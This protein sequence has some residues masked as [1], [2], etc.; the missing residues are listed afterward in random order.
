L[1]CIRRLRNAPQGG[2]NMTKKEIMKLQVREQE[3]WEIIGDDL[4]ELVN[5]LIDIN[6][7]LE[8]E[9]NQ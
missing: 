4:A 7:E 5:E 1:R 2:N 9:N 6:I 8:K 3:I